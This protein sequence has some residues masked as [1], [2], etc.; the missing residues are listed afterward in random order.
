VLTALA[1]CA[2]PTA[3]TNPKPAT[4][5][6]TSTVLPGDQIAAHSFI[7]NQQGWAVGTDVGL[8]SLVLHTVD[9]GKH[10]TVLLRD[11]NGFPLV[12]VSFVD[13]LHGWAVSSSGTL[14]GS[15]IATRDGGRTWVEQFGA[16]PMESVGFTDRLHGIVQGMDG[17]SPDQKPITLITSDGGL[18]WEIQPKK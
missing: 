15:I 17:N 14:V 18:H 8:G 3:K 13:A 7:D 1:G 2:V 11:D 10:W 6:T 9:G 16:G 5:E 4:R 12:G